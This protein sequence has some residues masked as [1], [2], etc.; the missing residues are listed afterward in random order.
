MSTETLERNRAEQERLYGAP[1]SDLL[2]QVATTLEVSQAKMAEVLGISAPMLSQLKSGQRIKIG[3]PAAVQRLQL[4]VD[5]ADGVQG[6]QLPRSDALAALDR[7]GETSGVFSRSTART[8]RSGAGSTGAGAATGDGDGAE[9]VQA[10][11][12]AVAS[13]QELLDAAERLRA[14]FPAISEVLE[15]YGAGRTDQARAHYRRVRP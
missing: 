3:N 11:L 9:R 8:P 7:A 13:A 12:R 1:L 5:L 10:L 6:G 14:D 4:L 2:A 15:V